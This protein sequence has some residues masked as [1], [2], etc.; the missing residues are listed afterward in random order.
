MNS[1]GVEIVIYK[2]NGGGIFFPIPSILNLD[3][4]VILAVDG[5]LLDT[6]FSSPSVLCCTL[7]RM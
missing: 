7:C 1:L 5:W 2:G 6:H 3:A 4:L